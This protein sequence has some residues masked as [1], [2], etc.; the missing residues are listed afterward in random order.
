MGDR[1]LRFLPG[2]AIP[3]R[4]HDDELSAPESSAGPPR[5]RRTTRAAW[6]RDLGLDT[7]TEARQDLKVDRLRELMART[8]RAIQEPC[9]NRAAETECDITDIDTGAVHSTSPAKLVQDQAQRLVALRAQA[10]AQAQARF[11]AQESQ[12]RAAGPTM[13]AAYRSAAQAPAF[14][15]YSEHAVAGVA[16]PRT[17]DSSISTVSAS[18][19]AWSDLRATEAAE[20]SPPSSDQSWPRNKAR[21]VRARSNHVLSNPPPDTMEAIVPAKQ[22]PYNSV[23]NMPSPRSQVQRGN[24]NTLS[25]GHSFAAE[26]EEDFALGDLVEVIDSR[27][28]LF[29]QKGRVVSGS[30]RYVAISFPPSEIVSAQTGHVSTVTVDTRLARHQLARIYRY[31]DRLLVGLHAVQSTALKQSTMTP[32]I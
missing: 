28:G 11:Q 32:D 15:T 26:L 25:A 6:S 18:I 16:P 17:L 2:A 7:T 3:P 19:C 10:Q 13:M 21:A 29:G 22:I 5:D 8:R 24:S 1:G 30:D 14:F 12:A 4:V 31:G 23:Q 27:S 20:P 9:Q